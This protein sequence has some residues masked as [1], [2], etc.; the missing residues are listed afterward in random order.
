MKR[1]LK[2]HAWQ[3]L[4]GFL[5][6]LTVVIGSNKAALA[7][8]N[9]GDTI[10]SS[11]WQKVQGMVPDAFLDY[12]KK[13]WV[14][15]KIGKLN[16]DPGTIMSAEAREYM[17]KNAGKYG[18]NSKGETVEKS[19]GKIDPY[20][21]IGF[22]FPVID[23][24]DPMAC[25][26]MLN[27]HMYGLHMRGD[28]IMSSTLYF[29]GNKMERYIAGPNRTMAYTG[30]TLNIKN[31]A[32]A[33]QFGKK[34]EAVFIMK[35]TDPY[36]LN[37]LATMTYYFCSNEP[38]KVFAY[39]PA[40]RRVR[41]MTSSARSDAMFGTD[42]ALDDAAGGFMGKPRDFDCKLLRTQETL[43]RFTS[44]DIIDMVKKPNGDYE[45]KKNYVS[46]KWGFQTPG[47]KGKAWATTNDIFV[48]RNVHVMECK[49]KDAYYNYGK[50]E[51]WF[52][53]KTHN[54]AYKVIWDRAGK[55][56][57]VMNTGTGCYESKDGALGKCDVAF[58][59]W[60]YDE[61]RDHAT[62][63]DEFNIKEIKLFTRHITSDDFTMI[64]FTKFSK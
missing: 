58:G 15:M 55:R 51:L 41:T 40:L 10:D 34:T 3:I 21:I 33:A 53:P 25:L 23:A 52:D 18:I 57:K 46:V 17:V 4:I 1:S 45:L 30:S 2:R 7:D 61:Q 11:N 54:P 22:P 38:D 13:G 6:V 8:V 62:S 26:M 43:M 5:F 50:F 20:D 28:M 24:K 42:Y 44:P 14:I 31:Q 32:S 37:G 56:W 27:N 12:V 48:K 35:V 60:I 39:I 29:V 47:W 63:V 16:F 64:G 19:T 59:D 49:A 36:E 9:V